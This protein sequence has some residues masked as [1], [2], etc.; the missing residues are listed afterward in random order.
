MWREEVQVEN[1]NTRSH[2]HVQN[3]KYD[4]R[5]GFLVGGCWG[6]GGGGRFESDQTRLRQNCL[7]AKTSSDR[8]RARVLD[9]TARAAHTYTHNN[10]HTHAHANVMRNGC[11]WVWVG[12]ANAPIRTELETDGR[13]LFIAWRRFKGVSSALPRARH[14]SRHI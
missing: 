10:M 3:P 14:L 1:R 2:S 13:Q 8:W 6:G 5:G 12:D 7:P 9:V 11:G 4:F